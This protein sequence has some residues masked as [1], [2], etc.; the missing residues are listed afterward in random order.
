[1]VFW[2]GNEIGSTAVIK[3]TL[4][5][6]WVNKSD[7]KEKEIGK[8]TKRTKMEADFGDDVNESD[9]RPYFWLEPA[10]SLNPKL[11]VELYDWKTVGSHDF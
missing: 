2:D 11:R 4:N 7:G 8:S 9:D 1:K 3:N 6:I 5:P 10:C